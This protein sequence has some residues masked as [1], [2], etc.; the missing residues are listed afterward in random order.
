MEI[1]TKQAYL[2][3]PGYVYDYPF[4]DA[5][6]NAACPLNPPAQALLGVDY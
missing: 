4:S 6:A 2:D 1:P 5:D 3:D